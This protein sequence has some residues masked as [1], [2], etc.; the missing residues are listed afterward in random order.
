MEKEGE[1]PSK[2]SQR[3]AKLATLLPNSL[4]AG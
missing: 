4:E 3:V 1:R 2:G